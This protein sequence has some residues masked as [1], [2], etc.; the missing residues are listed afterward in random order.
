MRRRTRRCGIRDILPLLEDFSKAP[1]G[2]RAC[3]FG[4]AVGPRPELDEI[5][6]ER[7]PAAP[8]AILWLGPEAAILL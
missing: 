4:C 2:V 8:S 5:A 3:G 7:F 6:G 1:G